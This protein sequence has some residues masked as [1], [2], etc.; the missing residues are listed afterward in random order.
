MA[1]VAHAIDTHNGGPSMA[2]EP[3][4][5]AAAGASIARPSA[6]FFVKTGS[7]LQAA[8][9]LKV[10]GATRTVDGQTVATLEPIKALS[11]TS[12]SQADQLVERLFLLIE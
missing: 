12:T 7:L 2:N 11:L 10:P 4:Y 1:A 9:Q 8:R 5:R 6:V 3:T